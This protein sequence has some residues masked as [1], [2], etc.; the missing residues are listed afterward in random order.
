[1]LTEEFKI[2]NPNLHVRDNNHHDE[3]K[4]QFKAP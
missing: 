2:V 3:S 1:M 4:A